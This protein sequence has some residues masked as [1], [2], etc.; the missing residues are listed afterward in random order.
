MKKYIYIL[1]SFLLPL[2]SFAQFGPPTQEQFITESVC[3]GNIKSITDFLNFFTCLA[4]RSVVPLLITAGTVVFIYGVVQYIAGAA[5]QTKREEGRKFIL[6]GII[7]LFVI[8]S[9][10]GLV[11]LLSNTFQFGNVLPQLPK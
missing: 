8:I 6:W 4:S 9:V 1:L 2:T 5:D 3:G 11:G 10:W 7:G